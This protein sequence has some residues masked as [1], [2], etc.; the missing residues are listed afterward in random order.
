MGMG[1]W[2]DGRQF[3]GWG[4][5]RGEGSRAGAGE[6][7]EEEEAGVREREWKQERERRKWDVRTTNTTPFNSNSNSS[8]PQLPNFLIPTIPH[9]TTKPSHVQRPNLGTFRSFCVPLPPFP[10]SLPKLH[11]KRIMIKNMISKVIM[12]RTSFFVNR[13]LIR[14]RFFVNRLLIRTRVFVR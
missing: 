1:A 4:E 2:V 11:I 5:G 3:V 6:A 13:L 10:P 12:I 8:T 9:S 7:K 14:T